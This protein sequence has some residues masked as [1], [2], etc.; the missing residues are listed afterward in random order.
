MP[1]DRATKRKRSLNAWM[2]LLG[3]HTVFLGSPLLHA[4]DPPD[5]HASN[6]YADFIRA[7]AI[8]TAL[9][10]TRAGDFVKFLQIGKNEGGE[11]VVRGIGLLAVD[12][13]APGSDLDGGADVTVIAHVHH[14]TMVQN[15]VMEDALA[16]RR[17]GVPNF[18]ISFDGQLIW[19]VGIISGKEMYRE[20]GQKRMGQWM[21]LK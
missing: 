1:P 20:I 12:Q 10:E 17:L 8:P 18:V 11:V 13:H 16:V 14:K 21:E 15:P 9:A 4:S 2:T 5:I 6:E 7:I 19:E 3:L